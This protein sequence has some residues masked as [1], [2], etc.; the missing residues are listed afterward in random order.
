[1]GT[2]TVEIRPI[3][4]ADDKSRLIHLIY[5]GDPYLYPDLFGTEKVAQRVLPFLQEIEDNVFYK[6]NY[7]VAVKD[8]VIVGMAAL[9]KYSTKWDTLQMQNA[10][11][12]ANCNVPESFDSCSEY[13]IATFNYNRFGV[14]AC[15][16]VVDN[17]YRR[18]G[19]AGLLVERLIKMSGNAPI[20]LCVIE[21]NVPA[22]NLY[23][24]YGFKIIKKY[25]DYGGYNKP[26]ISCYK[27]IHE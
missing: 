16:I 18:Q 9:Y 26:P 3:D 4:D 24:K 25:D 15:N 11:C 17:E 10:F 23:L 14:N 21:D 6:G 20:E 7:L 1:M 12:E 8:D 13:F 27:M 2:T 22:V 19:I 5:K